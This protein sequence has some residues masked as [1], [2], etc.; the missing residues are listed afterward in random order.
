MV[1]PNCQ[2]NENKVI[3]SRMTRGG[4]A[5]RR[6]RECLDC[7]KRFTTYESTEAMLIPFLMQKNAGY[8]ATAKNIKMMLSFM[9]NNLKALSVEAQKLIIKMAKLEKSQEP[10]APK[11]FTAADAVSAGKSIVHRK[12]KAPTAVDTVL[13]IAKRHKKGIHVSKLIGKTGYDD[14][15]VRNILHRAKKRGKIKRIG[16]GIYIAA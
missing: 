16:K 6:R 15:K 13:T 3:D 14:K 1:C 11:R 9:S 5:I 8:G 4:M 10:K 2:S 12:R 7:F